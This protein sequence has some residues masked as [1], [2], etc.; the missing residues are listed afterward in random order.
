MIKA[1][2]A[3]ILELS[4]FASITI[5]LAALAGKLSGQRYRPQWRYFIWI[6]LAV[7]L[8]LPIDLQLPQAI[9]ITALPSLTLDRP[10]LSANVSDPNTI[11][12]NPEIPTT[13]NHESEASSYTSSIATKTNSK[14]N[15]NVSTIIAWIWLL[16][17]I[18]Y[19]TWNMLKYR[20]IM[21]NLMLHKRP[22]GPRE[23]AILEKVKFSLGL[24]QRIDLYSCSMASSP[25]LIGYLRPSILLPDTDL[26]DEQL[27]L[28]FQHELIHAKRKDL[29]FMALMLWVSALH[30]FNPFIHWMQRL[31]YDDLEKICDSRVIQ[32]S[33][34]HTRQLYANTILHFMKN[35]FKQSS[36]LTTSFLRG[37]PM[38]KERFKA[39]F[40][41]QPKKSAAWI[42]C[43]LII[44]II[45]GGTLVS[46]Q[47]QSAPGK[48]AGSFTDIYSLF[49]ST[50][51]EVFASL[52]INADDDAVI[53]K[54]DPD[55]SISKSYLLQQPVQVQGRSP[56]LLL[57]F[58][59]EL[60]LG[61]DFSF[62]NHQ[63]AFDLSKMWL[64][65]LIKQHGD[66]DM[67]EGFRR[68]GEL[69]ALPSDESFP[70]GYG[71]REEWSIS[72]EPQLVL[73]LLSDS[74]ERYKNNPNKPR[75]VKIME[76]SM[77][78]DPS[79]AMI[80]RFSISFYDESRATVSLRYSLNL[81]P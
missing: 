47:K 63:D 49:G 22:V 40:H 10:S 27:E 18:G 64:D 17:A 26:T 30:W 2:F 54:L 70:D 46:C 35:D 71:Y 23:H 1:W 21:R 14:P 20:R 66:P 25:M 62:D 32:H 56:Y 13:S 6:I 59:N 69:T 33:D 60:L 53:K 52:S 55:D 5:I 80:L 7:R 61:S 42:S 58:H 79:R 8:A 34:V 77:A 28:V 73:A 67:I 37:E 3:V 45:T 43:I 11:L 57:L 16:G 81:N 15:L 24:K 50:T 72:L 36:S 78:K 19:F 76:E 48:N 39:I 41:H 38:I 74:I 65:E 75:T 29:W 12:S 68:V 44:F 51:Q 9:H 4:F 31:A